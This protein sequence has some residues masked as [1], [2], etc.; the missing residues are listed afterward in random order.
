MAAMA[1]F[2]DSSESTSIVETLI[3]SFSCAALFA[4]SGDCEGFRIVACTLCPARPN[5][6]AASSPIPLLV[7]V[8]STVAIVASSCVFLQLACLCRVSY[9]ECHPPVRFSFPQGTRPTVR[10]DLRE[11]R[12]LHS[13]I[14]PKL[15]GGR[16]FSSG[17]Q[18]SDLQVGFSP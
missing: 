9:K 8:I 12:H 7:P 18:G 17:G 14:L 11:T 13:T 10:L 15:S 4:S 6:S 1:S 2:T 16:S 3:G 5:A